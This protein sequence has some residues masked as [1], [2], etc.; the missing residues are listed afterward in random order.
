[1]C[2]AIELNRHRGLALDKLTRKYRKTRDAVHQDDDHDDDE[3]HDDEYD[4]YW[5]PQ[6]GRTADDYLILGAL[7]E[8]IGFA[9]EKP[10]LGELLPGALARSPVDHPPPPAVRRSRRSTTRRGRQSSPGTVRRAGY[11]PCRIKGGSRRG[12]SVALIC[13]A[14]TTELHWH[15]PAR[16]R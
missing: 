5:D 1:M 4:D 12:S 10:K 13:S 8:S 14:P 15:A 3:C 11:N 7:E 16:G 9:C 2:P 6:R